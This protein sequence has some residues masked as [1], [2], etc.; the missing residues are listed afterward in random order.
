MIGRGPPD[1]PFALV[2]TPRRVSAHRKTCWRDDLRVIPLLRRSRPC[3]ETRT[4]PH[5]FS[6]TADCPRNGDSRLRLG[7]TQR[8]SL[9]LERRVR[10][11]RVKGAI[12][13][14]RVSAYRKTYWRAVLRRRPLLRRSCPGGW[15][16]ATAVFRYAPCEE[17][18]ACQS[19]TGAFEGVAPVPTSGT[20]LAKRR[21]EATW[22]DD[23]CVI[24]GHRAAAPTAGR[25]GARPSRRLGGRP[26]F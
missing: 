19:R 11:E 16:G 12:G 24:R 13:Q 2:P 26:F 1:P 9:Q 10:A 5:R 25:D 18:S 3:L 15:G 6:S 7:M 8:S 22:R 4:H 17:G 20:L 14:R 21:T 23:L